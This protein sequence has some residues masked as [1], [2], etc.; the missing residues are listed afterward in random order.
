MQWHHFMTSWVEGGWEVPREMP[1]NRGLEDG[2]SIELFL[3]GCPALVK[4]EMVVGSNFV[5]DQ[6]TEV[7][8]RLKS[9]A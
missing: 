7:P 1:T 6:K 2:V 5:T 8:R 9:D 3:T 4:C